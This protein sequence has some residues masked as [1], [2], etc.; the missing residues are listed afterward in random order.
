MGFLFSE[1]YELGFPERN[2][3]RVERE[4]GFTGA[5]FE[6]RDDLGHG[7]EHAFGHWPGQ[8]I[9]DDAGDFHNGIG[10]DGWLLSV[11]KRNGLPWKYRGMSP[12]RPVLLWSSL[13][14]QDGV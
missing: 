3:I 14:V 6:G 2:F 13:V 11:G 9:D 1:A 8:G 10:I 5:I 7:V 12:W 4:Q